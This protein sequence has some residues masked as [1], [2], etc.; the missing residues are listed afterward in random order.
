V[1]K[2]CQTLKLNKEDAMDRSRWRKLI[3]F[4]DQDFCEWVNVSSGTGPPG[5]TSLDFNEERDDSIL[6]CSGISWII[7]KQSAPRSGQIITP[8]TPHHSLFACR[9]L[10][11]MPNQ[12]C[13]S[14]EGKSLHGFD[15]T[16]YT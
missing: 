5:E 10:F 11:L 8:V 4:D 9:M 1:E 7:F 15:T 6:G 3:I 2:D 13:Q 16:A 14:T 12:Q